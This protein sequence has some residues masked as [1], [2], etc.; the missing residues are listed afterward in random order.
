MVRVKKCNSSRYCSSG[1]SLCLPFLRVEVPWFTSERMP[2]RPSQG[3]P[4][5]VRKLRIT[6]FVEV[7][8]QAKSHRQVI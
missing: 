7:Y 5:H 4:E 1:D 2:I 8:M 3:G 6:G